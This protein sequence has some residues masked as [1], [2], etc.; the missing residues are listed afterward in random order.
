[1]GSTMQTGLLLVLGTIASAIGWIGLYP[2]D[3]TGSAAEQAQAIM[4]NP[5]IAKVGILLGY[6][7]MAAV[8]LGL[9]NIARG[10]AAAGGKGSSYGN[11]V[12]VLSIALLAGLI[13]SAGLELGTTEATSAAGGVTLMGVAVAAGSSFQIVFGLTLALLGIG[14]A[15]DKN[16]H[17]TA[18]ALAI[19]AGG[20]I[21]VSSFIDLDALQFAGWIGFMLT[22]L[23]LGGL[24]LKSKS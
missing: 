12:F 10:M 2:A 15:L 4:A 3:G 18:A 6:G 5:D 1:M 24:T 13:I 9:F 11:V 19:I 14:I 21:L 23:V 22:S 20:S 7:G 16:F 17:I 8:F